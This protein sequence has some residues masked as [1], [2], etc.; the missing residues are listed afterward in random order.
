MPDLR[1]PVD[2]ETVLV[3]ELEQDP[4]LAPLVG[5]LGDAA[6]ISTR[7]PSSF[8]AENRLKLERGGGGARGWPDYLDRAIVTFHAYGVDDGG[9]MSVAGWLIVAM[10]RIEGRAVAGGVITATERILGPV[11]QPDPDANEAPRYLV[12]YAVTAHPTA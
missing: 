8:T 9:A 7:L 5:G 2:L 6:R 3:G 4:D 12:Q 11:W 1:P 10:G